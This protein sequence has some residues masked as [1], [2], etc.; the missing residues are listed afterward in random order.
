[1]ANIREA[2]SRSGSNDWWK[3]YDENFRLRQAVTP[4]PWGKIHADLWLKG[5]CLSASITQKASVSHS[6]FD[7]RW[8]VFIIKGVILMLH[9]LQHFTPF[10][11]CNRNHKP[12]HPPFFTYVLAAFS[13]FRSAL[14]WLQ[15]VSIH[16]Q[17]VKILSSI[18]D[19]LIILSCSGV[20]NPWGCQFKF[21]FIIIF[22][23]YN[24]SE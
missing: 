24:N 3:I 2:E 15:E 6:T 7:R 18:T 21:K 1:M 17:Y 16:E 10:I 4:M 5:M 14:L 11:N 23:Y 19:C 20:E 22:A 12:T 13:T 8:D 9:R